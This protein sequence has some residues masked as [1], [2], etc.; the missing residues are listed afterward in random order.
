MI[1]KKNKLLFGTGG[2]PLSS[3]TRDSIDG[4]KRIKELGLDFMEMEFVHG[5]RMSP[6]KAEEIGKLANELNIALTIHGPY[7]I[8]LNA[9]DPKKRVDSRQRIVDSCH[10][11]QIAGAK[12]VCFHAAF[13]LGQESHQVFDM[14]CH[15]MTEIEDVLDQEQISGVFLAPELTGKETQFGD[16]EEL[17]A[18]AQSMRRTRLCIDFAHYFARYAGTRNS[19]ESFEEVI[20]KIKNELGEKFIENLHMH[21]SGINY[22]AKGERNHMILNESHFNWQGMLKV[23]KKHDVGGYLVC[24]SPNLEI[25]AL[26]AKEYYENL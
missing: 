17:I 5:V 21:F 3:K 25:D 16:L 4:I 18:L 26:Q 6:E 12:S 7:Y 24:E 19:T 20:L 13:N 15:E 23:L 14:V 8:N 2:V 22:S 10:I 11:A 1:K 9:I